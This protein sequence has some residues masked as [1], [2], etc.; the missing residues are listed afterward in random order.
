MHD[1]QHRTAMLSS[2]ALLNALELAE[3]EIKNV[4]IVISGAGSAA[5]AYASCMFLL[6]V[7]PDNIIMFDK[8]VCS[9]LQEQTYLLLQLKYSKGKV[10]I[11]LGEALQGAD[12]FF[13]FVCRKYSYPS[14]VIRYG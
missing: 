5:L 14:Y 12:V 10:G 4:K 1:D 11:Q 8:R 2:A 13:R 6:G 9:H 3:K 7:N